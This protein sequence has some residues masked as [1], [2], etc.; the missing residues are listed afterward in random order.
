MKKSCS[1]LLA[2][3]FVCL[4]STRAQTEYVKAIEKWR[5]DEERD[6]KKED[7]WLTLAGLFWLREG[8]NTVGLGPDFDVPLAG[9][10]KG[11]K[12]GEIAFK[13][14]VATLKVESGVEAQR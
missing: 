1:I 5:S 12:F 14:G 2:T 3:I 10:F 13:D 11:G 8:V 9:N 7:G 4:T 6:L